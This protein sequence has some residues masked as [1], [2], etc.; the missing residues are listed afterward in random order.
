MEVAQTKN[1]TGMFT[2]L[3]FLF[4]WLTQPYVIEINKQFPL[5]FL[6]QGF[7]FFNVN[8]E[9]KRIKPFQITNFMTYYEE[10]H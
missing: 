4:Y 9:F 3:S 1:L 6:S 8:Y 2:T 10:R 5:Y 7:F